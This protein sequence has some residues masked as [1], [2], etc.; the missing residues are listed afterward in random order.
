MFEILDFD[1]NF[2]AY[3]KKWMELNKG[4]FTSGRMLGKRKGSIV[5]GGQQQAQQE[6]PYGVTFTGLEVHG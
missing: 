6:L 2:K 1:A 3:H 4:R 5:A